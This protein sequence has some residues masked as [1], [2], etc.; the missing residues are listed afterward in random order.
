MME[1]NLRGAFFCSKH[2]FSHLQQT[3]GCIVNISSVQGVACE[4]HGSAYAATKS[5]LL[6]LTRGMALDFAPAGVRV[7]AICP[8]A[9]HSGMMEAYLAQQND[10]DA[11]VASMSS[12]IPLG[13]LGRPEHVAGVAYFLASSEA[14]YITGAAIVVDGGVLARLAF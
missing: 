8:G 7:N 2:A 11:V 10:P 6:A 13:F 5:G 4:R 3:K 14:S 12:T 9:I 1:T